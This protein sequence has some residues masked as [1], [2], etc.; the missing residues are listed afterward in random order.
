MLRNLSDST[1]IG[2]SD[3]QEIFPEKRKTFCAST[4]I[5]SQLVSQPIASGRSGGRSKGAV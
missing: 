2:S 4:Q 5:C 3:G 1:F